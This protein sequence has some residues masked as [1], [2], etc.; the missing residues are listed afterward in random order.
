MQSIWEYLRFR[1]RDSMLAG[2][3][4]ALDHAEGDSNP[5]SHQEAARR[6]V[7]QR[8]GNSP[9]ATQARPHE[10]PRPAEEPITGNGSTTPTSP[11]HS[12]NQSPSENGSRTS[13]AARPVS[14]APPK[15]VSDGTIA[16]QVNDRVHDEMRAE[17]RPMDPF[18]ARIQSANP[19]FAEPY[20]GT[21]PKKRGRPRKNP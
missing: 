3:Q 11:S 4:D 15:F 20:E 8:A 19:E 13:S 5:A 6:F 14:A 1:T 10:L 7:E 16:T 17:T 2:M 21:V 12:E 18:E 9:V